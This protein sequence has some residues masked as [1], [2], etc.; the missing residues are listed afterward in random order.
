MYSRMSWEATSG[1]MPAG[2]Q[3]GRGRF[4]RP[5]R[6]SSANMI[7]RRRPR[8]AAAR[9]AFLTAF[10]KPFFKSVLSGKVAFGMK[11]ARHQLAPAVPSQKVIDRAVAGWVPDGS[12]IGAFEI[13][14]VQHLTGSSRLGEARQQGLLLGHRHV[15]ALA[16]ATRLGFERLHPTLVKR[17][18]RSVHRAQRHAHRRRNRRL[19]HPTLAQQNHLNALP[20]HGGY[21]PA[22]R[23]LQPSDFAFPAFDHLFAPESDGHSESRGPP[24]SNPL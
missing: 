24:R 6:A 17:H 16:S 12:F 19:S 8:L 21:L 5:K 13:L 11:W 4:I 14:D 7:R 20:L 22:Q 10:G 18:V 15:L 9:L 23:R 2:A 1:L 3:H